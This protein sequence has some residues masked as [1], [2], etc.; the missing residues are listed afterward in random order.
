MKSLLKLLVIAGSLG[1]SLDDRIT[2]IARMIDR[3]WNDSMREYRS[4]F[5][6]AGPIGSVLEI[7]VRQPLELTHIKVIALRFTYW[8]SK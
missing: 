8:F 7:L 2:V 5:V 3:T 1:R 4:T 6:K